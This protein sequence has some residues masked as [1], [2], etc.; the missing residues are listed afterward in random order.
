MGATETVYP[1]VLDRFMLLKLLFSVYCLLF[2]FGHCIF[3]PLMDSY[4]G[5]IKSSICSYTC[6]DIEQQLQFLSI[7]QH[8]EFQIS[9]TIASFVEEELQGLNM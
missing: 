7:R 4:Q 8:H 6:T 2:S 9:T 5:F 1:Q 3:C